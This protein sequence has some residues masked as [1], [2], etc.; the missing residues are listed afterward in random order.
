MTEPKMPPYP[1][2]EGGEDRRGGDPHPGPTC[3]NDEGKR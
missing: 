3:W 1:G 2:I